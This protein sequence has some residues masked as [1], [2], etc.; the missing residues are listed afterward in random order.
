MGVAR[1]GVRRHHVQREVALVEGLWHHGGPGILA[2]AP[3]T[4][5][6]VYYVSG[7]EHSAT[8]STASAWEP[9]PWR[10]VQRAAFDALR[11]A[12]AWRE[13]VHFL[14]P[15]IRVELL[16]RTILTRQWDDDAWPLVRQEFVK[17]M[18]LSSLYVSSTC[19]VRTL[20]R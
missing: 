6:E 1:F 2:S 4:W 20:A 10:A 15:H 16:I 7:M 14:F 12:S 13:P 18:A 9:T 17:A 5:I 3:R 8:S 11:A 19:S